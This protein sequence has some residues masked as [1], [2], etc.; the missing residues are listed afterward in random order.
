MRK[1]KMLLLLVPVFLL[2]SCMAEPDYKT[3]SGE[4]I[5]PADT[6]E[7]MIHD[8]HLADAIITSKILKDKS[9]VGVDSLIYQSIY[10][11]YNY[12][13]EDFDQTLLYYTHNKLDSLNLMY[14]RVIE[15]FYVEK[16]E[17]YK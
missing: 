7:L 5:I 14:D 4:E 15:K 10:D 2:F 11:F 16:G 17:V 13:K 6:L 12:S 9:G 3:E 1:I 8:I